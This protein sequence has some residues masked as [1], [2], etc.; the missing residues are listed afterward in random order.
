MSATS[1]SAKDLSNLFTEADCGN[2]VAMLV[3][4]DWLLCL[5][6]E[7]TFIWKWRS[8]GGFNLSFLVY[9]FSRYGIL[10]QM[11]LTVASNFPM[12]DL[13]PGK[14]MDP[15]YRRNAG[16]DRIQR[17]SPVFSALR[18]YALSN[19]NAWLRGI[20]ILLAVP[21]AVTN[22]V[23]YTPAV[24]CG[25]SDGRSITLFSIALIWR[26][27][28][29]LAELLVIGITWWYSFQSYRT[30]KGV[31]LG[32]T[33]SSLLLYN[34]SIYFLFLAILYIVGIVFNTATVSA[35][36]IH[37]G[38]LLTEF[39]D[40]RVAAAEYSLP[41]PGSQARGDTPSV[42]LQFAAQPS[43][44]LPASIATFANPVHVD[45]ALSE[46]DGDVMGADG[47]EWREMDEVAS[48]REEGA[49]LPESSP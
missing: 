29:L 37:A 23:C 20:I 1:P 19:R 36:V 14:R 21:S 6:E 24:L 26:G 12:S 32:K 13:L 3:V 35:A 43:S 30:L 33:I 45:S 17:R 10:I 46:T 27:S 42:V 25:N 8:L 16:S 18:A 44:S 38:G 48:T 9:A 11:L 7:V 2:A 39:Y 41:F 5:G 34:G 40:P 31:K 4:Y 49:I 22:I 15:G 47:S 28:Q